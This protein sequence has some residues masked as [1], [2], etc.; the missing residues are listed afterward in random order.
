[1]LFGNVSYSELQSGTVLE[2]KSMMNL[3]HLAGLRCFATEEQ[4]ISNS[5]E[6]VCKIKLWTYVQHFTFS[7]HR[8]MLNSCMFVVT[9]LNV[10]YSKYWKSN[11]FRFI[12]LAVGFP[13]C[14]LGLEYIVKAWLPIVCKIHL[15]LSLLIIWNWRRHTRIIASELSRT[16][17]PLWDTGDTELTAFPYQLK[18]CSGGGKKV[19]VA[20][21]TLYSTLLG[22]GTFY[23]IPLILMG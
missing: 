4:I 12:F 1:M 15:K 16:P 3:L 20:S 18:G 21:I 17:A 9:F 7:F 14:S 5:Y 13:W 8:L 22:R 11:W 2:P 6:T 19:F 23:W 10:L